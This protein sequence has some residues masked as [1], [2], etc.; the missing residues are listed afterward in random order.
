[1]V[2]RPLLSWFKWA[3]LIAIAVFVALFAAGNHDT[4]HISLLPLPYEATMP[5]FLIM[6]VCFALGTLAGIAMSSLKSLKIRRLLSDARRKL[7]A[8]RHELEGIKAERLGPPKA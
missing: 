8:T 1:M 2:F 7:E 5:L 4:V 6:L 3:A